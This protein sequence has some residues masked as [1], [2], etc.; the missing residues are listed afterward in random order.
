M[1]PKLNLLN[2]LNCITTEASQEAKITK[3]CPIYFG[4]AMHA[5]SLEK[6]V[7]IGMVSGTR[8]MGKQRTH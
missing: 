5:N 1:E 6:S 4:H 2:V 7:V 3:L 8:K